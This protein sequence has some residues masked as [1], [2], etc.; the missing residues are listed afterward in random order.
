[1]KTHKFTA[2]DMLNEQRMLEENSCGCSGKCTN[3]CDAGISGAIGNSANIGGCIGDISDGKV[4]GDNVTFTFKLSEIKQLMGKNPLVPKEII[5]VPDMRTT[6]VLWEDNTVTEVTCADDDVY[7][8][9][10]GFNAALAVRAFGC[11][12]KQY[13]SKW[14]KIIS[15]RVHYAYSGESDEIAA[16]KSARKAAKEKKLAVVKRVPTI[17]K[18]S[19]VKKVPTEKAVKKST[20][21]KGK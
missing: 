10:G 14:F 3:R 20:P 15:R 19:V 11:S 2:S 6:K 12:K 13:K 21:K 4:D 1:M 18:V 8:W 7:T 16:K 5:C 17:K 9:E